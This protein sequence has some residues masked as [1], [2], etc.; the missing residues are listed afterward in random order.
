MTAR[1]DRRLA[2]ALLILLPASF[3][4]CFMLLQQQFEYPDILRQPTADILAK[5]QAGGT[6]LVATWYVLTLTALLLIPLAVLLH[7]A[8]AGREAPATLWVA[9]AFGVLA[10]LVQALG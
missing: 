7:R 6:S 3:T 10:G 5:F 9:T 2:A 4:V 8:L 1:F